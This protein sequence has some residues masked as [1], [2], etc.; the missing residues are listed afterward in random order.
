MTY[1]DELD[2]EEIGR[3]LGLTAGAVRVRRHRAMRRLA[4]LLGV[5]KPAIRE[6]KE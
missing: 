1:R 4:E 3:Q 6:F 2:S 5:T